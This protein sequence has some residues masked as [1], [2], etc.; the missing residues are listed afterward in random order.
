MTNAVRGEFTAKIGELE[1]K[2]VPTHNRIARA[3]TAINR[4]CMSI[5]NSSGDMRIQEIAMFISQVTKPKVQHDAIQ[6]ALV[7]HFEEGLTVVMKVINAIT[8]DK[9][10]F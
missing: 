2:I 10:N 1:L 6:K 5:A 7:G 3:E 4:S 9:H 8:R